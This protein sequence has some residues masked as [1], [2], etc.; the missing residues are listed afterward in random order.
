MSALAVL[1]LATACGSPEPAQRVEEGA[2]PAKPAGQRVAVVAS[3]RPHEGEW[4]E[5]L[6][7]ADGREIGRAVV[8]AD[9]EAGGWERFEFTSEGG[10][11]GE[12]AV[13]YQNDAGERDLWVRSVTLDG[14]PLPIEEAVYVRDG[15]DSMPG[16]VRMSW[17]GELRFGNL[18]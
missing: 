12:L 2:V 6:V 5:I 16:R 1:L 15:R 9:R 7:L 3:G 14:V 13:R 11:V 8:T 10:R 18:P 4:P 17:N